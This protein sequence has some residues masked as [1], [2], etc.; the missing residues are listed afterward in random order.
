MAY[1]GILQFFDAAIFRP[2]QTHLAYRGILYI[3]KRGTGNWLQISVS[4]IPRYAKLHCIDNISRVRDYVLE[5]GKEVDWLAILQTYLF[6]FHRSV[7]RKLTSIMVT[8]ESEEHL[9]LHK[10]LITL[11]NTIQEKFQRHQIRS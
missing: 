8:E 10:H 6:G 2:I 5:C 9:L 4:Q 7:W 1:R 3:R 11:L